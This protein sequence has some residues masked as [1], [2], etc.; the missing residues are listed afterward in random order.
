M[1]AILSINCSGEKE[2]TE[3]FYLFVGTYTGEG[4]EGIY[5]Y[6]FNAADGSVTP[7][8]TVSGIDDPSY[9]YLSPDHTTL[10]AVN[11][12]ADSADATVSSFSFEVQTGKISFMNRQSSMGGAP[13]YISTDKNGKAVFVANYLGGSLAMFPVQEDGSLNEAKAV[14]EHE[15]SSVNP[16][17][18]EA[19]HMHC[20]II[21]P[22]N[23]I[24]FAADLGTDRLT[25]YAYDA[26]QNTL[27]TEPVITYDTDEGAGPR[28]LTFHPTG[29]YA[30]LV[31]ELNGTAD[32]FKYSEGALEAIQTISTLPE[33]YE[34]VVSGADI[35]VSPDG[36]FVYVS[37][38]EDLNNIVIY[39]INKD[40]G[41]LNK[42]GAVPS[43]GV[44]PR[45]FMIDPTGSYLLAANR[46]S[47]NIVVFERDSVTGLLTHTGVEIEVSQPVSLQMAPGP[48]N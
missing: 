29:E 43:G 35:R 12:L 22:D 39:A 7:I 48:G 42:V 34:G 2:R 18:Q 36:R 38:R 25:G 21:S 27:S 13:C 30:Y 33:N 46:H 4:S 28:H 47:D 3:E 44:H 15:G 45:N 23:T 20:T 24:L 19:P 11:E 26:E 8:D 6:S 37:N 32:V 41:W 9:L 5:L 1:A 31:N 17:R 40:S 10:Y 14:I 16:N